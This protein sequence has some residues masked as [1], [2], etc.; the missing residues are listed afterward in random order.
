MYI[1]SSMLFA[2]SVNID[3]FLIGMSYGIRKIHITFI[4]NLIISLISFAGTFLS[5]F[6]GRQLLTFLPAF[7]TDSLGSIIL[8]ALGIFYI[9]KSF[10][11][12]NNSLHTEDLKLTLPLREVFLVGAALSLNNIGIGIGLGISGILLFPTAV[13]TC[14]TSALFLLTGNH[15]GNAAFFHTSS[16]YADLISGILLLLLGFFNYTA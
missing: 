2:F 15:I 13:I 12:Q 7:L 3:A 6:L 9:V 8:F 14:L 5:L 1:V 4:H 10:F 16:R 11:R